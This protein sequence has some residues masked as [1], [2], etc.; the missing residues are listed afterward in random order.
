LKA[1]VHIPVEECQGIVARLGRTGAE[2]IAI[3]GDKVG[4]DFNLVPGGPQAS[5]CFYMTSLPPGTQ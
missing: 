3:A 4:L 1:V 2:F 5:T